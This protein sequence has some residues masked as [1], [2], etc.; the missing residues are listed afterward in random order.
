M[1]LEKRLGLLAEP[2]GRRHHAADGA[3]A[4]ASMGAMAAEESNAGPEPDAKL[5]PDEPDARRK[6]DEPDEPDEPK[7]SSYEPSPAEPARP[8]ASRCSAPSRTHAASLVDQRPRRAQ[9]APLGQL[10]RGRDRR[11]ALGPTRRQVRLAPT[12]RAPRPAL[13]AG[14]RAAYCRSHSAG[15]CVKWHAG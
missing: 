4:V 10:A 7:E 8:D 14:A 3:D 13:A 11:R 15:G 12:Q 1:P 5:K 2:G 6:P 9:P